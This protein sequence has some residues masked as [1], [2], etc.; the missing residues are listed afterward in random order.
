M[1]TDASLIFSCFLFLSALL[2][3]S[4][5]LLL[6]S[7]F[8]FVL[9]FLSSKRYFITC[10]FAKSSPTCYILLQNLLEG[11][12]CVVQCPR[13]LQYKMYAI[14]KLKQIANQNLNRGSIAV[15]L[16][17]VYWQKYRKCLGFVMK[18]IFMEHQSVC[19]SFTMTALLITLEQ[20]G[21]SRRPS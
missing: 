5:C 1:K 8:P 4:F 13:V 18:G 2:L 16:T 3:P 17:L 19:F 7:F 10:L 11:K 6:H 15:C 12:S 21:M 9:S 14:V 20:E